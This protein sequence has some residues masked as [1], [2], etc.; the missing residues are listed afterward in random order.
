MRKF[1]TKKSILAI[2]LVFVI[3]VSCCFTGCTRLTFLESLKDAMSISKYSFDGSVTVNIPSYN[4]TQATNTDNKFEFKLVGN[5]NSAESMNCEVQ[6][7]KSGDSEYNKLTDFVIDGTKVYVNI[8]DFYKYIFGMM[9]AGV[10]ANSSADEKYDYSTILD[11]KFGSKEYISVD[12]DQAVSDKTNQKIEYNN[13]TALALIDFSNKV[14]DVVEKSADKVQPEV[15]GVDGNKFTFTLSDENIEQF[16]H[17]FADAFDAEKENLYNSFVNALEKSNQTD[18]VSSLKENK[19]ELD[20]NV[21]SM[22]SSMKDFSY[23]SD[24]KFNVIASSEVTNDTVKKWELGVDGTVEASSQK[25]QFNLSYIETENKEDK[26]ISVDSSKVF[27]DDETEN[28]FGSNGENA[29]SGL[30]GGALSGMTTADSV[31]DD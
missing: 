19:D 28:L 14:L 18:A 6:Y 1:L 2:I 10:N 24:T 17:N 31:D 26:E 25:T 3:A 7:K 20:K 23:T 29:L 12:I 4:Y 22:I 15:L 5:Y 8:K 21:S 11:S 27:T 30:L 9:Y 13:D 16:V